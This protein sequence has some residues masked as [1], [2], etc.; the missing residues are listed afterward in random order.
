VSDTKGVKPPLMRNGPNILCRMCGAVSNHVSQLCGACRL[1]DGHVSMRAAD[2]AYLE[3]KRRR[4]A[5]RQ[6]Q[7]SVPIRKF[8]CT[9]GLN[10]EGS[11]AEASDGG[12]DV[13]RGFGPFEWLG[14]SITG[15]DVGGD[16]RFQR[17]CR[18]MG[19]APDLLVGEECEEALDLVGPCSHHDR[20]ART[21]PPCHRQARA[22]ATA[23]GRVSVMGEAPGAGRQHGLEVRAGQQ[24]LRVGH[25]SL[26]RARR[27]T[28][29]EY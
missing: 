29:Q 3:W 28:R 19:A 11:P 22:R 16:C 14:I 15:V 12:E 4:D 7:S 27:A 2:R 10:V 26:R 5:R 1:E 17:L 13:V 20:R 9:L 18:A 24:C 23:G 6:L 8:L 25:A 21:V